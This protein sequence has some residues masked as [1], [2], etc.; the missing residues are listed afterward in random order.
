MRFKLVSPNDTLLGHI[1]VPHH[2][3]AILGK[4]GRVRSAVLNRVSLD[5]AEH[6]D[7]QAVMPDV[8]TVTIVIAPW[9]QYIGAVRLADGT[10]EE[11]ETMPDCSFAPSAAY[12]R[13][14]CS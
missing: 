11:F 1:D 4:V 9:S 3:G 2:W 7:A 8:K 10:L 14:I 5:W 6:T 13:S 12:L